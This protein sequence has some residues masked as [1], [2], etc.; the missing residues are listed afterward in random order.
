MAV[1]FVGMLLH[2]RKSIIKKVIAGTD[3]QFSESFEIDGQEILK[4]RR[5]IEGAGQLLSELLAEMERW[6]I[7]RN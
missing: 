3:V 5:R 4:D 6:P 7:H 2:Q 1:M